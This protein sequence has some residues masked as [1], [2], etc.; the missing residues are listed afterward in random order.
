MRAMTA[1]VQLHQSTAGEVFMYEV[2]DRFGRNAVI[3]TLEHEGG[4][5]NPAK[6]CA[7]IR[8]KRNPREV[9]SGPFGRNFQ[10]AQTTT[11][12]DPGSS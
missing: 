10:P 1:R 6:I 7:V 11:Q 5:G 9:L 4:Y 2:P 8:Q 3:G 12:V